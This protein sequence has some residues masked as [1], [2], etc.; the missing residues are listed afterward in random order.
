HNLKVTGSNPVP[1][2]KIK[3]ILPTI[4]RHLGF[5]KPDKVARRSQELTI[6]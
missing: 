4:V 1:A 5:A 3:T 2:T 6:T